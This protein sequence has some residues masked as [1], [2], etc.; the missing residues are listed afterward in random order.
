[1][2]N[3]EPVPTIDQ[4]LDM[5][6]WGDYQRPDGTWSRGIANREE[7]KAQCERIC[8]SE[9]LAL[10]KAIKDGKTRE[11]GNEWDEW[12]GHCNSCLMTVES[13]DD[14]CGCDHLTDDRIAAL[15]A[16]RDE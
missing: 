15:E 5:V 7:I 2:S 12:W 3:T 4:I 13:R 16:T 11:E 6:S 1:M 9:Q 10:L 8:A 14:K